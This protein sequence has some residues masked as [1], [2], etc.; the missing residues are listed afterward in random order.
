M[1]A[2]DE[3]SGA[4]DPCPD[5]LPTQTPADRRPLPRKTCRWWRSL[6]DARRRGSA[7]AAHVQALPGIQP[8]AGR[9]TARRSTPTPP[10][11][12]GVA[13][14]ARAM[15]ETRCGSAHDRSRRSMP[16][17]RPAWSQVAAG[18]GNSGPVR[19]VRA[20]QGG[21]HDRNENSGAL[22]HDHRCRPLHRLRR[23]H[24]GLRRRK[25]R[26]AGRTK[27][28]T[29]AKAS[30][31]SACTRWITAKTTPNRRSAFVPVLCQQCGNDTPCVARLPA[32]GGGRG[33]GHRASW[34]RCPSAASAAATA[35]R[36]A[37]ITRAT[38]TGGTRPGPPAW[39]RR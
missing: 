5:G 37:P 33:P 27:A 36:P 34:A 32:A 30:P 35:W 24:G 20:R 1:D 23:L 21:A 26:P 28:P 4:A 15:L 12:C 11:A 25:Q 2:V 7:L 10:R 16:A 6:R 18:A 13:D 19:R 39:R 29:I 22:R 17:S 31:G 14:G 3:Q 8:A 38:S 9:R